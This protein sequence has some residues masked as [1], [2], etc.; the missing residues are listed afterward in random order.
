MRADRLKTNRGIYEIEV[1]ETQNLRYILE[2][3]NDYDLIVLDSIQAFFLPEL[4]S[5]P[6]SISQLK[7]IAHELLSFSKSNYKTILVLAHV[8]K[9]GLIAGPKYLEHMV[10]VVLLMEPYET[11]RVLRSLKNRYGPSNEVGLFE[12]TSQGLMEVAKS[13]WI[14][15]S[16]PDPGVIPFIAIEGRR[17]IA[18]EI[19]ALVTK[20]YLDR[21]RRLTWGLDP[22]RL[23]VILSILSK[24]LKLKLYQYDIIINVNGAIKIYNQDADLALAS[25]I[26]SSIRSKPLSQYAFLSRL[27]LQG[28]LLPLSN[29]EMR[30]R[31]AHNLGL[32]GA[33]VS[34]L[35]REISKLNLPHDFKLI[36]LEKVDQLSRLIEGYE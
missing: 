12:M 36:T 2:L 25:S 33:V 21:P 3:G 22:L 24:Y 29:I 10:D 31:E 4:E 20:S 14:T 34:S 26:L 16:E 28:R 9:E 7:A 6:S 11:Y 30:L 23:D 19:Q 27:S 32:R 18:L 17:A 8:T 15:S 35:Q 1:L 13:S 5:P